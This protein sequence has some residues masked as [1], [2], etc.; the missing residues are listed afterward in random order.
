LMVSNRD[1]GLDVFQ[2]RPLHV[3]KPAIAHRWKTL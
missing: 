1:Q 3:L 2:Y